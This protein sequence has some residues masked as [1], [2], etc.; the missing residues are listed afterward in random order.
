M[1][2]RWIYT[3]VGVYPSIHSARFSEPACWGEK[4]YFA[5]QEYQRFDFAAKEKLLK[6]LGDCISSNNHVCT[7]LTGLIIKQTDSHAL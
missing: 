1:K 4:G 3:S 6:A 5:L 2:D 7:T